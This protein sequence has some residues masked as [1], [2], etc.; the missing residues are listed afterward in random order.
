MRS[1]WP[2]RWR[3]PSVSGSRISFSS[4][5]GRGRAAC[6]GARIRPVR[7]LSRS[8]LVRPAVL[9]LPCF[10]VRHAR[11]RS[12]EKIWE[13]GPHPTELHQSVQIFEK[14]Y[15]SWDLSVSGSKL[16]CMANKEEQAIACSDLPDDL[17]NWEAETGIEP[18]YRALQAPAWP[19]SHQGHKP[20]PI[21]ASAS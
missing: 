2:A 7:R 14:Y 4:G 11:L 19:L 8:K 20:H 1:G 16:R 10:H 21:G 15:M 3:A 18:V 9:H 13:T 5:R 6:G 12:W 17:E